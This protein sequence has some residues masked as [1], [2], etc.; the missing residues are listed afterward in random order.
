M[1]PR[2]DRAERLPALY[3]SILD[4]VADLERRGERARAARARRDA[5]RMYATWDERAERKMIRLEADL[6]RALARPSTKRRLPWV[7]ATSMAANSPPAGEAIPE[8]AAT[9]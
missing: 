1:D 4:A 5:V 8:G 6:R 2:Q 3:R 7:R 9:T